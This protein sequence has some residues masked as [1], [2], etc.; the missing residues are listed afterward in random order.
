MQLTIVFDNF[1]RKLLSVIVILNLVCILFLARIALIIY[2]KV[3]SSFFTLNT[4]FFCVFSKKNADYF[5]CEDWL[6]NI[7]I[8]L[9]Q[10]SVRNHKSLLK[11]VITLLIE[12]N[13]VSSLCK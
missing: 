11:K 10:K 7:I 2:N 3:Y 13:R 8:T 9:H 1:W 6:H 5:C 12:N 4:S